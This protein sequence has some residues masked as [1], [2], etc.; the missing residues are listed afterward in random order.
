M[1]GSLTHSIM[2]ADLTNQGIT[3]G[4]SGVVC[5]LLINITLHLD[6]LGYAT[7]LVELL[8]TP[9]ETKE[10]VWTSTSLEAFSC[11]CE[12]TKELIK[13][14]SVACARRSCL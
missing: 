13:D 11:A 12:G 14:A 8:H 5:L 3:T 4:L 7:G 1:N 6:K 9:S 10:N 2:L